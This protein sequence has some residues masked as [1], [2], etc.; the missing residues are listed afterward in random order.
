MGGRAAT[1]A[2]RTKQ[3]EYSED[4]IISKVVFMVDYF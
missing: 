4:W 3:R 2:G 1:L